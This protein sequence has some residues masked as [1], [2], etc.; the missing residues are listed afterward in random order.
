[1]QVVAHPDDDI[2]FMNPDL[3][4]AAGSG[5]SMVTV[6]LTAGNR[7]G[8]PCPSICFDAAGDPGRTRQRQLGVLNAQSR[9]AG[10]SDSS[11]GTDE[12]AR[13]DA[14]LWTL[15]ARPVE[16]YT[17]RERP[18]VQ[19]IFVNLHDS[20]LAAIRAGGTDTA[21]VPQG[22]LL[23]PGTTYTAAAV[24]ELLRLLLDAY[25][26]AVLRVH[27]EFPDQRY[28]ED[29]PDHVAAAQFVADAVLLHPYDVVQVNYRD[30]NIES[31]PAN[32]EPTAAS[33]KLGIFAEYQSHDHS[34]G[35]YH[36]EWLSRMYYR[37][38]RGTS[39]A[40]LNQDGRP[41]V[42]VVRNGAPDTYWRTL[43][44][45]WAGPLRFSDPGGRLAPALA[46]GM[47]QDGR[48]ELFARRLTDH[49]IVSL[50]Q[51]TP[52]GGWRTT[53]T[54]HGN[55]NQGSGYEAQVGMPV[56][57]ADQDGRLE[58]FVKNAGGGL[59]HKW[60]TSINGS[61]SAGWADMGGS[62]LQDPVTAVRNGEGRIEVFGSTRT[63]ILGWWQGAP[64]GT[65]AGPGPIPNAQPA[66]PPKAAVGQSGR[67]DLAY[68]E[69]GTGMMLVSYQNQ[70]GGAWNASPINTGGHGGVGEPAAATVNGQV[71]LFERNRTTGVSVVARTGPNGSYGAWQDLGGTMVDG[72]AAVVDGASVIH[73]F[74]I[75]TDGRIYFRTG[76]TTL[77]SW[78]AL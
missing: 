3:A 35:N 12:Y 31:C 70:V 54:D 19:L 68:R 26:P 46:V 67:I 17:L 43:Q 71:V 69:V 50:P 34:T 62:D 6:F 32:L 72:P 52:N 5:A 25:R 13:W 11:P 37:W 2:L 78:Q 65:F 53:W 27:D 55:P 61:W 15:N 44:G 66:S 1:M 9:M 77:G 36:S 14:E 29:H 22:S 57:A 76:T 16:K 74:A 41:Q 42:F 51:N 63:S 40:G 38:S 75:S 73:V 30:Y 59:S 39:W 18:G 58:M 64:N 47:N 4:A 21:V 33:G 23:P 10:V 60:Q 7:T 45:T 24:V 56:V 48:M 49:H 8:D 20:G 28:T